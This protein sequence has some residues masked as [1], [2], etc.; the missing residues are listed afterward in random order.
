[1]ANGIS[2]EAAEQ[3]LADVSPMWRAFWF[4]MHLYAK[5]IEEFCA[6]LGAIDDGVY[7]YHSSE[8]HGDLSRWVRE[9]IGDGELADE[10]DK[11]KTR[12]EAVE[13]TCRRV[14][15]LKKMVGA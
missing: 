11:V 14:A 10:L 5:N 13:V 8:G 9:V 7:S 12:E 3:Y 6:G 1:M 15:E 4:H 2:K